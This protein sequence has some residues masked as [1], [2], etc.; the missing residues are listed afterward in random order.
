MVTAE[1]FIQGD[2]TIIDRCDGI[3]M[4]PGWERSEGARIELD[5]A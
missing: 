4:I 5:H 2:L 3:V 1:Q